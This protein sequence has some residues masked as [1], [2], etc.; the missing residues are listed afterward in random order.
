MMRRTSV[1]ACL[2]ALAACAAACSSS[3]P[4]PYAE[5]GGVRAC[6]GT[7]KMASSCE[8]CLIGAC[9]AELQAVSGADPSR[10]GGACEANDSCMCA[11]AREGTKSE[12]ECQQTCQNTMTQDCALARQ[13][14]LRCSFAA[15]E[16]GGRCN[17]A[18]AR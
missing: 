11:C 10:F 12:S 5:I 8:A 6:G 18:C 17:S 2:A 13:A 16:A 14:A 1:F 3:S 4:D 7:V 9:L 15:F